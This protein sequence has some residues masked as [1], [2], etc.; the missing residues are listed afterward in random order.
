M[1][2]VYKLWKIG[3]VLKEDDIKAAV[4]EEF[5][6]DDKEEPD[7]I[8]IAFD[9][10]ENIT[11]TLTEEAPGENEEFFLSKKIGGTSN[12]Y[13]LYPNI[14]VL[15]DKPIN[16]LGLLENT[17]KYCTFHFCNPDH[18]LII[19][20]ILNELND[21]KKQIKK[22]DNPK[23]SPVL[24][25]IAQKKK[26]NYFIWFS[27]NGK[28]FY[29]RMPEVWDNWYRKPVEKNKN[30]KPGFDVFTN[31]ETEVGYKTDFKVYSYDQYHDSLKHRLHDNLPL[32]LES[33][34]NIKFAWMY[35]LENLVFYYKGLEYIIIP[36][37][38]L[39]DDNMYKYIL[40]RLKEAN[41]KTGLKLPVIKK[42][43]TQEEKLK[44]KLNKVK[45]NEKLQIEQ[46][47]ATLEENIASIDLGLFRELN[48]QMQT[49][50]NQDYL[51]AVTLDYIFT[52]I[53]RTNLSFEIKGSIEDV[54]P[55]R[56]RT[57]VEQMR[58]HKIEDNVKL[59]KRDT[60][61]TY[62]QDFFN[63]KEL[64]FAVNRTSK[65]N[66]NSIFEERLYLAKLLLSDVKIKLDDLLKRF[67]FNRLYNYGHTKRLT[68][69]HNQE[70]IEFPHSFI[71][72]ESAVLDFLTNLDK[73]KYRSN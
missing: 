19:E 10:K 33:A 46:Q 73:I 52:S 30:S 39:N 23:L 40:E 21:L 64:Y 56:M 32:S 27:I 22:C 11:I 36:N 59:G 43:K 49:I 16:K 61:K 7:Y 9:V 34:R 47:I 5:K 68:K 12:A 60:G 20:K 18:K 48:E 26:A 4:R 44:S 62:L 58:E 55:S 69:E 37:L 38:L 65:N 70:W 54:I 51:N 29:E 3:S 13:Y 66:S 1:S 15:N 17:L 28:N 71:E 2:L 25:K 14:T 57:V 63:R 42:M 35:I 8:H 45:N 72:K 50:E 41:K 6:Y 67:E 24:D 53:N 31:E